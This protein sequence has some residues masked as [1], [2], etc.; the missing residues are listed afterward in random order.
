LDEWVCGWVNIAWDEQVNI[1]MKTQLTETPWDEHG[2][3]IG[4]KSV[5]WDEQIN[6]VGVDT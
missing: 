6:I 3:H 1:W 2:R 4:D 5:D